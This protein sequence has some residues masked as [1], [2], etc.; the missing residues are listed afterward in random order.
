MRS[1]RLAGKLEGL[2]ALV[3]GG[4]T[5]ME[6][7]KIPWGMSIEDT[8]TEVVRD[9]GYPVFFN[10]PAGHQSENRALFIGRKARIT[11]DG[12]YAVLEFL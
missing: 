6:D 12:D 1:L 5:G 9:Y 10:F 4:F 2:A 8:I 3:A 11:S 7:T